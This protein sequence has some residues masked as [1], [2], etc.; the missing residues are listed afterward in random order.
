MSSF[1]DAVWRHLV[2]HHAADEAQVPGLRKRRRAKSRIVS[3]GV[4]GASVIVA[5]LVV[6]IT[7]SGTPPA[8]ALAVNPGSQSVTVTLHNLTTG[9]PALNARFAQLGID[10]TAVPVTADCTAQINGP[11]FVGSVG[12]G[13][14][15]LSNGSIP[16]H[17][18]GFVA[19]RQL[20]NGT[21]QLTGGS[22]TSAVP[23]CLPASALAGGPVPPAGAGA[24]GGTSGSTKAP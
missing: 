14:I 24:T 5:V 15:T 7:T 8:Y 10:E 16:A 11:Y 9:I 18:H 1:E 6:L 20:Q 19:A 13:T 23:P 22:T 17:E 2:E 21:I 3:L 4:G 12:S